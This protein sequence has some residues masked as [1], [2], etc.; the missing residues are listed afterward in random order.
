[1][2]RKWLIVVLGLAAGAEA[3]SDIMFA[4]SGL[5]TLFTTPQQRQQIDRQ[6]AGSVDG[7]TAPG[8]ASPGKIRVDGLVRNS[9]GKSIVW[10]NGH[11]VQGRSD[12]KGVKVLSRGSDARGVVLQVDGRRVRVKPGESWSQ[13]AVAK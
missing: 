3:Q 7:A 2:K 10:V 4:E 1:M 8:N 9:R 11:A 6:R 13:N 5:G 12:K